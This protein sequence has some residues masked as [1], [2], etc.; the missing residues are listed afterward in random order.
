MADESTNQTSTM[1]AHKLD[2]LLRAMGFDI[3]VTVTS[4]D[5][6]Q[7]DIASAE[8]GSL[9]G[10]RG[11]VLQ[12]LQ[13]VVRLL[14]AKEGREETIILD[15]EEYRAKSQENLVETAKRKADEVAQNG[16]L[17]VLPPMSS[18]ERRLVHMALKERTDVVTESLGEGG[19]RRVMIKKA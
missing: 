4:S 6:V 16:R 7:L 3:T 14:V 2:E 17:S 1:A 13:H 5:P 12:A 18:Y 10:S 11:E 9:I 8:A 19:N 15:I